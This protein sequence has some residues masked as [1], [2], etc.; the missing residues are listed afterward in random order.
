[1]LKELPGKR[2]RAGQEAGEVLERW[3]RAG[4]GQWRG[5]GLHVE[6]SK[7]RAWRWL[8]WETL[9]YLR[10]DDR[11][12]FNYLKDPVQN[13]LWSLDGELLPQRDQS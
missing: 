4:L 10:R 2:S 1:M 7:Q 3:A 5:R 11:V 8:I 6:N 9:Q 13:G 12:A